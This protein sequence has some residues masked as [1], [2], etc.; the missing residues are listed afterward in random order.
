[1]HFYSAYLKY[2]SRVGLMIESKHVATFT[3]DN[4]ISYV[5]TES[6]LRIFSENT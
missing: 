3:I 2:G 1:M 6:N 4:K 5:L